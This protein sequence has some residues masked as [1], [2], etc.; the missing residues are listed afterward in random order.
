MKFAVQ[1]FVLSMLSACGGEALNAP[2]NEPGIQAVEQTDTPDEAQVDDIDVDV[3]SVFEVVR[4]RI[5]W[6]VGESQFGDLY[7]PQSTQQENPTVVVIHGGCWFSAFG[8]EYSEDVAFALAESGY[9]TWNIEYRRLG[10]G[11]EF[12]NMFNDITAAINYVD[13]LAQNYAIDNTVIYAVG[14]SAGGHL[15]LWAAARAQID[16][17]SD[18]YTQQFLP[19]DGVVSLAGIGDLSAQTACGSAAFNLLGGD[20]VSQDQYNS[21]FANGSPQALLPTGVAALIVSGESD[22]IVPTV[23]GQ[24]YV[25]DALLVGDR[26]E[27]LIV[28][29]AGHFDLTDPDVMD[30]PSLITQLEVLMANL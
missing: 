11:G 29:G 23:V 14:H 2:S 28:D 15:A 24:N 22:S 21:R 13:V 27:H 8:L 16:P 6:G 1:I 4:T 3:N 9:P 12:P 10:N 30:F 5:Q 26:V 19:V 25:D 20:T 18:L 7:M 17:G